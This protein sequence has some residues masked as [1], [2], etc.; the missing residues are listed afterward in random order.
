VRFGTRSAAEVQAYLT[1]RR[2]SDA[3]SRTL[4]A[5][6]ARQRLVDDR[7]SAKLWATRLGDQGYAWPVIRQRL[8]DK[9]FDE[10]LIHDVL[11]PLQRDADDDTRAR[12]LARARSRRIPPG[13]PRLARWL[14]RRGFD[15]D[16]IDR[17]LA[18]FSTSSSN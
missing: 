13:D 12:A 17:V 15:A 10:Q 3:T 11:R 9:G 18:E 8:R 4:M 16:L 6:C 2:V 1:A 14:A 7:A 5:E